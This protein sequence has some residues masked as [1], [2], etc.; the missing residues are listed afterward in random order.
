M[1]KAY[2]CEDSLVKH[3]FYDCL[4]SS[5]SWLDRL[6]LFL[7]LPRSLPSYEVNQAT[8]TSTAFFGNI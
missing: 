7:R 6:Q 8:G 4:G 3:L 2:I 1:L 5:S